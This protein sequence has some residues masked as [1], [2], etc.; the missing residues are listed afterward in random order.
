[1]KIFRP[2]TRNENFS[3]PHKCVLT[4]IEAVLNS[5]L[6]PKTDELPVRAEGVR[7]ERDSGF[8]HVR[9]CHAVG[10]E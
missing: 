8:E 3:S 9:T 7:L 1:M 10:A 5:V 6:A 4:A 2:T